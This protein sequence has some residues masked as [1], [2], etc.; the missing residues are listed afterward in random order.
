MFNY[1]RGYVQL[2]SGVCSTTLGSMFNYPREY[3]HEI[4]RAAWFCTQN[5]KSFESNFLEAENEKVSGEIFNAGYE[6]Q[7]VKEIAQAVKVVIG[8]DVNLITSPTDDNRSYHISS[9]KIRKQLGFLP[10]FSIEKAIEDLKQA[11]EKKSAEFRD[12]K[13]RCQS[14][15]YEMMPYTKAAIDSGVT[16]D[17]IFETYIF[18]Q[19]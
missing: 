12:S 8:D 6:N 18:V 2:P 11:F 13:I 16:L 1:P 5:T 4:R 17:F 7:T 10:Q 3:V 15:I 14:K 9:N 19:L